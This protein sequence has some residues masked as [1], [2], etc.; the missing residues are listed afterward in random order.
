M[1]ENS[2]LEQPLQGGERSVVEVNNTRSP[3][4]C[5]AGILTA[6]IPMT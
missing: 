4:L 2:E 6:A 5:I 3:K 1:E